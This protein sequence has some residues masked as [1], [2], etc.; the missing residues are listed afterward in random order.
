MP[1]YAKLSLQLIDVFGFIYDFI[2]TNVL[3]ILCHDFHQV[4]FAIIKQEEVFKN[5][6]QVMLRACTTKHRIEADD[7]FFLLCNPFPV[8]KKFI[9]TCHCPDFGIISIAEDDECIRMEYMRYC[10]LVVCDI[11]HE[12]IAEVGMMCFQFKEHKRDAIDKSN[13]VGPPV[14]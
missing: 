11:I 6:H 1:E 5:I 2:H 3:V 12:S 4:T 10:I 9:W 13:D 7:A 8:E 14:V